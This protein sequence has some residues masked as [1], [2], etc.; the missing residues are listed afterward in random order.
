M[1]EKRH[2]RML[3]R[4]HRPRIRLRTHGFASNTWPISTAI[5][6]LRH[7]CSPYTSTTSSTPST[8]TYRPQQAQTSPTTRRTHPHR[9]PYQD[10][11][12][13][14]SFLSCLA[15]AR[16]CSRQSRLTRRHRAEST[17]VARTQSFNNPHAN[18]QH[19]KTSPRRATTRT[20]SP[21]YALLSAD[22]LPTHRPLCTDFPAVS[23][24]ETTCTGY[25]HH[26]KPSR[27]SMLPA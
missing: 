3:P 2:H 24:A 7:T 10:R 11:Q 8:P 20:S 9:P 5:S 14:P 4:S 21:P 27:S 6:S 19:A 23:D 16:T 15:N 22:V 18:H 26:V 1:E 17:D 13:E 25:P 12:A